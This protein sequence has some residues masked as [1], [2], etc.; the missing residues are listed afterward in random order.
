M[1][2]VRPHLAMY[3]GYS[4]VGALEPAR[5]ETVRDASS[6]NAAVGESWRATLD[7]VVAA[8][9]AEARAGI[10]R[11]ATDRGL[12]TAPL[13]DRPVCSMAWNHTDLSGIVNPHEHKIADHPTGA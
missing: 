8:A 1:R 11:V 2:G 6:R 7:V 12:M 3:T 10:G 4:G 13:V 5:N 9:R